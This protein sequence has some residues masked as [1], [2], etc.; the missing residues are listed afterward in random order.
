MEIFIKIIVV[1]L[2][3]VGVLTTLG[4]MAATQISIV[5]GGGLLMALGVTLRVMN[6]KRY[7][8]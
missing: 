4:G 6:E 8:S 7:F 1:L 5:F 3:V 2:I